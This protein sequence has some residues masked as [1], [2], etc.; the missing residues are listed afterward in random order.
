[1]KA[2]VHRQYGPPDV[3]HV[4]EVPR[5]VPTDDEILVRVR[6]STV[7]SGDWHMR[8]ADPFLVRFMNGLTRP[9]KQILGTDFAGQVVAAGERVTEFKVGDE[10]FGNTETNLG[11][12]AE[13]VCISEKRSVVLKP[14]NLS[15]EEAAAIPFGASTSLYFLQEKGKIRSG[16]TVL[17]N[18]A[19]GA[20]GVYGIQ[21]AKHFGAE[22]TGV[23]S[24][25]NVEFVR[26]LGADTVVDYTKEDFTRNGKTYDF[27]Y[28]TV[29]NLS[30]GKIKDSLKPDGL[31]LVAAGNG[32]EWLQM[33]STSLGSGKKVVTG[34]AMSR[35]HHL[36]FFKELIEAGRLKPVIDRRYSLEQT[37]E[38]HRYVEQGHKRGS[39]VITI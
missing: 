22:V 25:K 15:P 1:M 27:I 23:C 34:V 8:K 16:H 5:P 37:A 28:E 2:A 38:A 13:F 36:R 39:V 12:N 11:T 17:I 18:G 26:S 33:A 24:T 14:S 30:F 10:V 9:K 3:L 20:V 29:G 31:F 7:N 19:S 35:K 21:L 32:K 6:A 4:R